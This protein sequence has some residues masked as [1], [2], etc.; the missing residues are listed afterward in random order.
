MRGDNQYRFLANPSAK[1]IQ[2]DPNSQAMYRGLKYLCAAGIKKGRE[3]Q[4]LAQL[5]HNIKKE[6]I[7]DILEKAPEP[8]TPAPETIRKPVKKHTDVPIQPSPSESRP[9]P[10][11]AAVKMEKTSFFQRIKS[12][13]NRF[14]N[15]IKNLFCRPRPRTSG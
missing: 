14:V 8:R 3:G 11:A 15:F 7:E 2:I 5:C 4:T 10:V 9:K 12:A 1:G 6:W 13:L